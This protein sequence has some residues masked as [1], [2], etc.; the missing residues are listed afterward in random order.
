M[1][2]YPLSST[3]FR[4]NIN[5]RQGIPKGKS[6]MDNPEKLA[7]YVIQDEEK[8]NKTTTQYVLYTTIRKQTHT[9]K[10]SKA[11]SLQQTYCCLHV[12]ITCPHGAICLSTDCCFSELELC[13]PNK[14][15]CLVQ[16]I[17]HH[18]IINSDLFSRCYSWKLLTWRYVTLTHAL[19][20]Y[21]ILHIS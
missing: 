9:K 14:W 3:T 20:S 15:V 1:L 5:K 12:S 16:S 13:N 4:S 11:W 17:Y 19:T 8:Q 2:L 21:Y 18:H 7:A 6:K 10:A